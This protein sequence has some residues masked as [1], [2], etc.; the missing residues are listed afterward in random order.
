[1]PN[2]LGIDYG[3]KRIGLAFADELGVGFPVPAIPGTNLE[4]W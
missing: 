1:M 4:G 3:R 2:Y